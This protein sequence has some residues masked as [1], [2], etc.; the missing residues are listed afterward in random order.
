MTR[1][2]RLLL[3]AAGAAGARVL[4]AGAQRSPAG[5]R[6]TRTNHRGRPV[7]L[8]A[9]PALATAAAVT[10]GA[11]APRSPLGRGALFVGLA[12]GAL[13]AYDDVIGARPGELR[14]KGLRGH[15]AAAREGRISAGLVKAGGL[16]AAGLLAGRSVTT[17]PFDRLVTGAVVAGT[18]N[19]VNLFD[20]RP[21]RALKVGLLLGLP[22]LPGPAGAVLAGPMGAAAGLL[23]DDLHERTMLGD[24]GANALGAIVGLGLAASF[25]RSGRAALLGAL[26]ALT[27]ASERVS[28]TA[29]IEGTPVLRQIDALGR[30]STRSARCSAAL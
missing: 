24:S 15:L 1:G 23:P 21:G 7:S 30:Q 22:V 28:F 3:A 18:A 27:L 9:G 10:A 13:G 25:G 26:V 17:A 11:G 12:A 5:N 19:L 6:F 4:L 8:L 20:L 2:R 14:D 16:A 29:V